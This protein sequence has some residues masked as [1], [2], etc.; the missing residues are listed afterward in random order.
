MARVTLCE[1][2]TLAERVLVQPGAVIGGDGFGFAPERGSWVKVPQLGGVRVGA[3]VD[4][5]QHHD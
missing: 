2:V 5:R 3:D 1:R 4:R